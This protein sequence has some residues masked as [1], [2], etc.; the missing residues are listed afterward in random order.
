MVSEIR[1]ADA[2]RQVL[3]VVDTGHQGDL[4]ALTIFG[5]GCDPCR[6]APN[7]QDSR[8][9]FRPGIGLFWP[10]MRMQ[11]LRHDPA[12]DSGMLDR[13]R[14]AAASTLAV[15]PDARAAVL[16]GSRARGD[17]RPDSDWD[18][19]FITA[20]DGKRI[21][22]LPEGLP[23]SDLP[24]DVQCL[25]APEGLLARKGAA[26]GH[27]A[28]GIVRDGRPLAG[29]W[30][31]PDKGGEPSAM[32]TDEYAR[33]VTGAITALRNASTHAAL[34]ASTGEWALDIGEC[35][36]FTRESVAMAEHL[37][38]AMLGRHGGGLRE[39]SRPQPARRRRGNGP[40]SRIW[41]PL[42]EP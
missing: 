30:D 35:N 3:N 36:G 16:F 33:L 8:I 18:V 32:Q 17:H 19:A 2:A 6:T 23:A 14:A 42:S 4:C 20:G 29:V 34:L 12:A 40:A 37:G 11:P 28:R 5:A 38:K 31:R 22:P 27:V 9:A 13:I 25:A 26:I 39:S 1:D 41:R 15:W 7:P 24:P 10:A 21:R